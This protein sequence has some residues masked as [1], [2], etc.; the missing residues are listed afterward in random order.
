MT[1][2]SLRNEQDGY[3]FFGIYSEKANENQTVDF[4]L[5]PIDSNNKEPPNYGRKFV[6]K[7]ELDDLCYIIKNLSQ[8]FDDRIFFKLIDFKRI[9]DNFLVKIG[10]SFLLFTFDENDD[11][12]NENIK[13]E[14]ILGIKILG[15]I[16][17]EAKYFNPRQKKKLFIGKNKR[18]DII[19]EDAICDVECVVRFNKKYGWSICRKNINQLDDDMNRNIWVSLDDEALIQEGMIFQTGGTV[20]LCHLT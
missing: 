10:N 16:E 4:S 1:S 9:K 3:T 7:Y 2:G 19:I 5:L 20:F 18:C 11:E 17:N 12:L 6:I 14:N 8:K 15:I 13:K